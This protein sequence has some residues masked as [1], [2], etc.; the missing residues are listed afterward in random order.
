MTHKETYNILNRFSGEIQCSVEIEC[1][2]DALPSMKLGL[3]VKVAIKENKD[4]S[5]SDLSRLDLRWS[6]L[7]RLDLSRSD[8]SGSNLRKSNLSGSNLSGSNLSGSDLS[9]SNLSG[10]NL[11]GSDLSDTKYNNDIISHIVARATRLD[12]YEFFAFATDNGIKIKAGCKY[13]SIKE[14]KAHV[15]KNYPN[16]PKAIETLSIIR[17]IES[18]AKLHKNGRAW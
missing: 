3:A 6:N 1:A 18:M 11:S 15:A 17:H 13:L 12:G 7:S 14:A 9:G 10:S 2:V 4:L 16:T 8:L 5:G